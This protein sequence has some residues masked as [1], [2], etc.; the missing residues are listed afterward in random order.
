MKTLIPFGY[1]DKG[2]FHQGQPP[3]DWIE[4]E[5]GMDE[6]R[7]RRAARNWLTIFALAWL[8]VLLGL[9]L[10]LGCASGRHCVGLE[11][12]T[13]PPPA[14]IAALA[15]TQP[16]GDAAAVRAWFAAG[17]KTFLLDARHTDAIAAA[18]AAGA[19]VKN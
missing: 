10:M 16:P 2:G 14:V 4:P 13:V 8:F 17:N 3:P 18:R 6:V 11:F 12:P 19:V 9:A 1:E 5:N 7:A 15:A